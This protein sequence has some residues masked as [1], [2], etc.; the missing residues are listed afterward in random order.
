MQDLIVESLKFIWPWLLLV[1]VIFIFKK[2]IGWAKNR[3]TGALVFGAL[4][5]M[6][7]PDPYAE[8]TINVVQQE[9]KETK[10]ETDEDSKPKE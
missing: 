6:I 2:L 9:E 10:K 5:Q 8:R 3:K 1:V 7:M 4:V